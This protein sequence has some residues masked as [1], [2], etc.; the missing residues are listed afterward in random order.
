MFFV[1]VSTRSHLFTSPN[2]VYLDTLSFG[3]KNKYPTTDLSTACQKSSNDK[4]Y[5]LSETWLA[6]HIHL[7]PVLRVWQL[8]IRPFAIWQLVRSVRSQNAMYVPWLWKSGCESP[9]A[10]HVAFRSDYVVPITG[11]RFWRSDSSVSLQFCSWRRL[12]NVKSTEDTFGVFVDLHII[13]AHACVWICR[14]A[15]EGR[16][17]A[18][19][20]PRRGMEPCSALGWNEQDISVVSV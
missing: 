6:P 12:A 17:T 2:S 13:Q 7:K 1:I 19:L 11:V 5:L 14:N 4:C 18:A 10:C 16:Q 20:P 9:P 3:T 8:C 15:R